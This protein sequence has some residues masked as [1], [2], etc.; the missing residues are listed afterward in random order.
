MKNRAKCRKCG[1]VIESKHRHDWVSCSC[2]AI[3]IDGGQSYWRAGG[4]PENFIRI[5]DDDTEVV[6]P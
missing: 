4:D 3:Y 1:D 5:N 6:E 2:K